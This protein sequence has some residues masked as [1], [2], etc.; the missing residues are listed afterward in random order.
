MIEKKKCVKFSLTSD[1]NEISK[2]EFAKLLKQ[3]ITG[4]KPNINKKIT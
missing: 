2:E 1:D 4:K 3:S